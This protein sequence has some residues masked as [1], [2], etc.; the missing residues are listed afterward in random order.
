MFVIFLDIDGVLF[1]NKMDGSVQRRADERRKEQNLKAIQRGECYT[2]VECDE[3]AVDLFDLSALAALDSLIH[4]LEYTGEKVGI[5]ISSAW[6]TKGDTAFLQKLFAPH[7]FSERIIGKTVNHFEEAND[8]GSQIFHWLDCNCKKCK[9]RDFVI[10]DDYDEGVSTFFR[11]RLVLCD[12]YRLLGEKEI[13]QALS[14]LRSTLCALPGT[15][16]IG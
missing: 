4:I 10:L 12:S 6:R 15:E 3:A 1:F 7:A 9:V 5:V 8:R 13:K 16:N 14:L 2:N 11:D